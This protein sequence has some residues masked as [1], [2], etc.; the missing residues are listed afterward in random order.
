MPNGVSTA[1]IDLGDF[2]RLNGI[3]YTR[4]MRGLKEAIG[5]CENC[6]SMEDLTIHHVTKISQNGVDHWDN[7]VVLCRDCHDVLHM[8]EERK[9]QRH[10]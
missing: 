10:A 4:L 7:L 5:R 8:L 3:V 9:Y 2:K 6:G 1:I